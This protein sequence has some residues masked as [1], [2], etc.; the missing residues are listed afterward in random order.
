MTEHLPSPDEERRIRDLEADFRRQM[1]RVGVDLRAEWPHMR[2][3]EPPV[4]REISDDEVEVS[5]TINVTGI[6]ETLRE[7][8]D[9]AGTDAFVAAYNAR[10]R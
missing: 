10:P 1:E 9:G 2:E 6:V 7:L 8:P 5:F 4:E 3:L